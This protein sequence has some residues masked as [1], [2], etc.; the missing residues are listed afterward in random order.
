[1][2]VLAII[3][4]GMAFVFAFIN[5]VHDGSNVTA[6]I[7]ASRSFTAKKALYVACAGE[8]AG[9]MLLGTAVAQTVGVGVVS[10]GSMLGAGSELGLVFILA[11]ILGGTVWNVLTWIFALPSSSSHAIIGG[12]IGSGIAAFGWT[13]ILWSNVLIK[14]VLFMFLSPMLGFGVGY[15]V[16]RLFCRLL[17]RSH[18]RIERIIT[19]VQRLTLALLSLTYG[20][21]DAQKSMG[22]IALSLAMVSGSRSFQVELWV[23]AGCAAALALGA[24]CGGANMI[25]AI[26]LRI[27]KLEPIHSFTCQLVT[28]GVLL[29]ATITG[30]PISTTQLISGTVMGVGSS[31]NMRRVNWPSVTKIV[32]SWFTTIP[33]AAALGAGFFLALRYLV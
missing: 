19:R 13:A 9:A 29:T 33:A 14:V 26:G 21:N 10:Q 20:S 25:R 31:A 23:M 5:G 28:I 15:L 4:I 2:S 32:I 27:F 6:T 24:L 22:L 18:R 1:M 12:L 16:Y 17:R 11:A 30:A 7:V 8:F 3:T